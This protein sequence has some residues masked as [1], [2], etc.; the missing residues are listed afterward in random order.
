MADI[1]LVSL[2]LDSSAV[3]AGEKQA[4][5]SLHL[6]E[7]AMQ[8]AEK[9]S[10][11]LNTGLNANLKRSGDAFKGLGE[12][13]SRAG[14]A[15]SGLGGPVGRVGGEIANL[16]GQLETLVGSLGL[17]GGAAAGCCGGC[18]G[19]WCSTRK[20]T[21]AGVAIS[22]EMA[23]I[24][25]T[26]GLTIDQVQRLGAAARLSGENIGLIERSFRTFQSAIVSAVQ[27][28]S[29]DAAKAFPDWASM[30]SRRARMLARHSF[31]VSPN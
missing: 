29:S 30:Q 19:T 26:T 27:D 17:V 11:Q 5:R 15:L 10:A 3:V 2:A 13:A 18:G 31:Q 28:P 12:S 21:L 7:T 9:Q 1:A 22:D 23:D 20:L 16:G 25:E 6:V 14:S 8:R 4:T 24:A